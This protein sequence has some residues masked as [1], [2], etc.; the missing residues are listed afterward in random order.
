MRIDTNAQDL[1]LIFSGV[2]VSEVPPGY[3]PFTVADE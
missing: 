1:T 2:Q 3:A